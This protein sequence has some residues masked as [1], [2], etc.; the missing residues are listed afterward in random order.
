[1]KTPTRKNPSSSRKPALSLLPLLLL[2][3]AVAILA[4]ARLPTASAYTDPEHVKIL[5]RAKEGGFERCFFLGGGR[6]F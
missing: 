3:A 6:G 2:L 4:A 5:L 1:M